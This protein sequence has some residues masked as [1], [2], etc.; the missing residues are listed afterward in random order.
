MLSCNAYPQIACHVAVSMHYIGC[1]RLKH[2]L[3]SIGAD[4]IDTVIPMVTQTLHPSATRNWQSLFYVL[5]VSLSLLITS[6]HF[7]AYTCLLSSPNVARAS[8]LEALIAGRV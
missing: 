6:I 3:Y 4:L 1:S 5:F 2:V 7:A 8:S